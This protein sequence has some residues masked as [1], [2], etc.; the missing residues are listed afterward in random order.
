MSNLSTQHQYDFQEEEIS[1]HDY[2]RILFRGKWIIFIS[3]FISVLISGYVAFTMSPV[4]EASTL[5]MVSPRQGQAGMLFQDPFMSSN[6]FK[7][8]N[9]IEI[10]KSEY[11]ARNV[12]DY[13]KNCSISDSLF[14]LG[15]KKYAKKGVNFSTIPGLLKDFLKNLLTKE[16]ESDIVIQ[17]TLNRNLV[18]ALKGSMEIESI[19]NTE[20]IKVKVS[21]IDPKEAAFIA[22]TIVREYYKMDTDFNLAEVVEIKSFIEEQINTIQKDLMKAEENLQNYQKEKGVYSLQETAKTL[23]EQLSTFEATYY[24]AMA[25]LEVLK[26]KLEN[27]EKELN[28]REKWVVKEAMN[29][30]NPYISQLRT[31]IAE[32]EAEKIKVM[33]TQGI[34]PEHEA[35]SEMNTRIRELKNK[36]FEES[37]N[38]TSLGLSPEEQSQISL[39]LMRNVLFNKIN[40]IGL[41]TKTKEYKRLVDQY[42]IKLNSLPKKNLDYIRLERERQVKEKYYILLK[43]KHQESRITEASKISSIRIIDPAVPPEWPVKPK[44]KLYLLLGMFLGVGLGVGIT[45]LREYFDNSIYTTEHMQEIGLETISIIPK[46]DEKNALEKVKH[47]KKSKREEDFLKDRMITHYD[48]KSSV[49]EAYRTLRTNIQFINPDNP[50]KSLVITSAGPGDGKSTTTVNIGIAFAKLGKKVLLIDGDLR[51]PVQHKVFDIPKSPGLTDGLMMDL[52]D[53]KIIRK[54]EVENLFVVTAG[55]IP[56]NPSEILA[57]R[58]LQ[59][60]VIRMKEEYDIVLVDSPPVVAVTDASIISKFTDAIFLVVKA[61]STDKRVLGRALDILSQVKCPLAGGILNGVNIS[62]GYGSYYYYY[63]SAY[64]YNDDN[65]KSKKYQQRRKNK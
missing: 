8:N 44:K 1:L 49:A 27:Q 63:N 3:F 24:S 11:L 18:R 55:Q 50:I 29:T 33:T 41:E 32:F 48:P 13:L 37:K 14:F 45:F 65:Q 5:I 22:N 56:P 19:R 23:I 60:Y 2:L 51:K 47:L 58:K 38:L 54:T 31:A 34:G 16:T 62:S 35:I 40:I 28:A 9:E 59:E 39:E 36:L 20:A 15:N 26:Q 17:D 52:K 61:G 42:N 12:I 57:S 30:S 7:I 46:I 10:L 43:T 25:D 4:Y 21:S 53:E 6:Y 64:Q